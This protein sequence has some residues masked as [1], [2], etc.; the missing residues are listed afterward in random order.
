MN[1]QWILHVDV[2]DR[3][4]RSCDEQRYELSSEDACGK[5]FEGVGKSL[6]LGQY[7]SQAYAIG[8]NNEKV[9]FKEFPI[10]IYSVWEDL[11]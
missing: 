3:G 10:D 5:K 1:T 4:K 6:S 9:V 8:P 2:V 11:V 7:I